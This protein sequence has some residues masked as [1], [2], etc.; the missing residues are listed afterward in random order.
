MDPTPSFAPLAAG[1]VAKAE[2]IR[3]AEGERDG[4]A[5]VMALFMRALLLMLAC[6][7]EALD[8]RAAADA[9]RA[10]AAPAPRKV[11]ASLVP[12]PRASGP[13]RS[14]ETRAPRLAPAP[15]AQAAIPDQADAP[16]GTTAHPAPA[17]LRLVWSR[18][19]APTQATLAV[20]WR[21]RRETRLSR[22]RPRTPISLRYRN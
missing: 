9:A 3:L 16:S 2:E 19:P 5:Q 11:T 1:L 4:L 14:G 7:C 21:P 18:D 15:E 22:H 13:A 10:G 12:A 20:P 17:G 8:A 6:L